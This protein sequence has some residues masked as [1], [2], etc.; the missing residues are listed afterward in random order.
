MD[1]YIQNL[2]KELYHL[3]NF[4]ILEIGSVAGSISDWGVYGVHNNNLNIV[5]FSDLD[6]YRHIDTNILKVKLHNII[7]CSNLT[8]TIVLLEND[9]S[10]IQQKIGDLISYPQCELILIDVNLNRILYY[11]ESANTIAYKIGNCINKLDNHN[12]RRDKHSRFIIRG[13]EITYFIVV[14]NIIFYIITAILSKNIFSSDINVLVYM[15]AK[16]NQLISYG[17]YYR[18]ILCM[19]LHGGI[20]H[21]GLNMYALVAIGP[22]VEK[23]YG[24]LK[25][26]FIYFFSGII[27]SVFSY[28]FS[29]S[30][31]IGASGAI[32][33]LFGATLIFAL[34][35][36]NRINKE[37][38]YSI[39]SVIAVNLILG[40]SVANVDNF[41]HVG[42]LL[43]GIVSSLILKNRKNGDS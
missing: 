38:I 31:S 36:K 22:L 20:I 30:I 26:I 8:L 3:Y 1:K 41:G 6:H 28:I 23:I 29:P 25:Y 39:F 35:M 7:G 33:G 21:L 17:Q 14:L 10:S 27:A 24:K 16:V 9:T 19:F 40:F 13:S 43:G 5:L 2:I 32:F 42:G 4:N 15:G 11:S 18:L 34:K 37:F 12:K